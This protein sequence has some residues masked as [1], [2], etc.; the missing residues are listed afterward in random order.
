MGQLMIRI[1]S[2]SHVLAGRKYIFG[3]SRGFGDLGRMVIYFRELGSAGNYFR[4]ARE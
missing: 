1:A 2:K 3:A 4:G